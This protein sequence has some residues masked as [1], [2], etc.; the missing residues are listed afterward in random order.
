M[1]PDAGAPCLYPFDIE[2]AFRRQLD[3]AIQSGQMPGPTATKT[4]PG[5]P[6]DLRASATSFRY[7]S[8][9]TNR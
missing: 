3:H 4:V 1:R 9:K 6:G 5:C 7:D 2:I 8:E